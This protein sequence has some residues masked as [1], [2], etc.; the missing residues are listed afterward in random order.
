MEKEAKTVNGFVKRS[1]KPTQSSGNGDR[2]I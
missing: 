2:H 1:V